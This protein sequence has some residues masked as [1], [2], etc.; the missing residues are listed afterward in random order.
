MTEIPNSGIEPPCSTSQSGEYPCCV[1]C[2][3][4]AQVHRVLDSGEYMQRMLEIKDSEVLPYIV[5]PTPPGVGGSASTRP[6]TSRSKELKDCIYDRPEYNSI[7]L[8]SMSVHPRESG[9]ASRGMAEAAQPGD[10]I[11][12]W[13]TND[14]RGGLK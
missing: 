9:G 8:K 4:L 6:E 11:S 14:D 1:R 2:C 3:A 13:L 7:Y 10:A 12:Y 5:V